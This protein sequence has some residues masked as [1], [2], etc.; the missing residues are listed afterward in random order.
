M[1][2]FDLAGAT[3][4]DGLGRA[5]TTGGVLTATGAVAKFVCGTVTGADVPGALPLA[6]AVAAG[7][8]VVVAGR[9][10]ST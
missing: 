7:V 10:S 3:P 5:G 2:I 8:V 4:A 6:E 1:D 9:F